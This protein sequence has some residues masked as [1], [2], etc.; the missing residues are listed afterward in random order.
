MCGLSVAFALLL[1]LLPVC[2][3]VIL[4]DVSSAWGQYEV[5]EESPVWVRGLLDVRIARSGRSSSW[6]SRGP[7]KTRYGGRETARAT[8]LSVSQLALE[9]GAALP[10][11]M[12]ARAQ[13]NWD[14]DGYTNDR[15]LLIEAYLRKEWGEWAQGWGLQTGVMNMPF[16]LEHTGPAWTP[17]YTLTPS[18]LNSWLWE[19][20]HLVGI[21]GEWWRVIQ[22]RLRLGL[23][24]GS[25]FGQDQ[26][27]HL[28]AVR[29]WVLSDALHGVNSDLPLP[30]RGQHV[31]AFDEQDNRPS[32]YAWLTVRD[33][34]RQAELGIGYFDNL[35]DQD[36]RGVWG[37]RFGTLGV[38]LHP[39][40]QVDFVS[41]Y[42]VGEARHR[43]CRCGVSFHAFYALLSWHHR[44]HR[45]SARY[46]VFRTHNQ[47][48]LP[49]YRDRGDAVTLAYLFEFGLQHRVGFEYIFVQSRHAQPFRSSPSDDGG[50]LSYRF[51]Y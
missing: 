8:R 27:G 29:G 49:N 17:Q 28:L 35:G 23:L 12:V 5:E 31:P 41:Q 46:D 11:D 2:L 25:G 30:A 38:I 4:I 37:T 32:I 18:A 1:G 13:L 20:G 22:S 6:T 26:A 39:L 50:Q 14:P 51:R 24:L 42:L 44:S 3:Q 36:E 15:P 45:I 19:E 40:P 47:D 21:E 43:P 33:L 9:L 7:G 10:W 34:R 16:S 48:G